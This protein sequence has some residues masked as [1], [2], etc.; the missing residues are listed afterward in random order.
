MSDLIEIRWHGSS[1]MKQGAATTSPLS[2]CL[3]QR[4]SN[5]EISCQRLRAAHFHLSHRMQ[6]PDLMYG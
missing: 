3:K 2:R 5:F 6:M 4:C 1:S